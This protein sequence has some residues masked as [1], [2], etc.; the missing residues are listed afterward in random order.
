MEAEELRIGNLV[1]DHLGR[2]QKVSETRSDAYICYLSN[3]TKLKYKLNTTK[4][5][6]LT[7]EYHL[8]LIDDEFEFVGFGT[9][10]VYQHKIHKAIKLEWTNKQVAVY[11]NDKLINF[12]D[13]LHELQNL[14][15]ALTN[16]ELTIK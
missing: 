7:E 4:P 8:K 1:K 13:Y 15:F 11:F 5:I 2:V 12:K 16:E 3:G 10:L 14:Y 6:A 9:R